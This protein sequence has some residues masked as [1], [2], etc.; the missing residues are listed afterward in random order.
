MDNY[1]ACYLPD[2]GIIFSSTAFMAAVPCVNGSS[3]VAN[4]Y[5]MDPDGT[6]RQLCFDQEH[7][8]CPTVLDNGRVLYLRWE[9]TDTP[10]S[11]DRVL[12]SMN[13][14]GTEQMEYYGSNSYWPNSLVLRPADPGPSDQGRGHRRRA[15]RRAA[16]GRAGAVRRRRGRREADGAVQRIPGHG[17]KVESA[18]EPRATNRR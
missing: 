5:R 18:T 16:D 10:H 7:N 11:H 15:P 13:P 4:F 1:D 17:R 9:Y 2:G 12:F 14:D 6:I 3:R 8:W